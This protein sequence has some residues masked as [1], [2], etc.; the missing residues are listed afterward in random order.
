MCRRIRTSK[1]FCAT[2]GGLVK[3]QRLPEVHTSAHAG[4][5]AAG[6]MPMDCAYRL[7]NARNYKAGAAVRSVVETFRGNG[8]GARTVSMCRAACRLLCASGVW[9]ASMMLTLAYC[10]SGERSS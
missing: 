5:H 8:S 9:M 2:C 1:S 4:P 10:L 6:A 7:P 3:R